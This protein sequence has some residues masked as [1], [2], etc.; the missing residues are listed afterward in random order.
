M[1]NRG[2]II[3]LRFQNC[4]CL[5]IQA[6]TRE[7]FMKLGGQEGQVCLR[8]LQLLVDGSGKARLLGR[9]IPSFR[10]PI[11]LPGK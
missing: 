9:Q 11:F 7:G 2:G 4:N 8:F 6:T 5:Y 3:E 10:L 1:D